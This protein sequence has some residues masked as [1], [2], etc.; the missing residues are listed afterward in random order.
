MVLGGSCLQVAKHLQDILIVDVLD[1]PVIER[2]V[3]L[4]YRNAKLQCILDSGDSCHQGARTCGLCVGRNGELILGEQSCQ[5]CNV[6]FLGLHDRGER[7]NV[8]ERCDDCRVDV[9]GQILLLQTGRQSILL[10][11]RQ[12]F[13]GEVR[14]RRARTRLRSSSGTSICR[15]DADTG[16]RQDCYRQNC[17]NKPLHECSP[18]CVGLRRVPL[19]ECLLAVVQETLPIRTRAPITQQ[20]NAVTKLK[21]SFTRVTCAA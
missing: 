11:L 15:G 10:G 12:R 16:T 14:H 9:P 2:N 8:P 13:H 21:C 3:F 1:Q 17:Y 5:G 18:C 20:C 19:G 4:L 6:L 7:A